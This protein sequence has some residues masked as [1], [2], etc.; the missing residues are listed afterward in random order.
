MVTF[1][2]ALV[3]HYDGSGLKSVD[4]PEVGQTVYFQPPTFAEGVA[5]ARGVREGDNIELMVRT[6]VRKAL[7]KDG[8]RLFDDSVE[9]KAA[10]QKKVDARILQR[11]VVAMG[12]SPSVDEAKND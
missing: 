3:A 8:N 6:I 10:L 4:V 11:I 2:D 1:L 7:D 9:T 5:I 12:E